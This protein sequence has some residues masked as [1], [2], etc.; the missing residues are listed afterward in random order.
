M[1]A[2][3]K[4][5]EVATSPVDEDTP[6]CILGRLAE[7]EGKVREQSEIIARIS[8]QINTANYDGQLEA[9]RVHS[10]LDRFRLEYALGE[11]DGLQDDYEDFQ[12]A[13]HSDEY[14]SAFEDDEPLVTI[15]IT[16]MNRADLLI[17][18]SLDSIRAQTYRR[19][20]VVVVG[21]H[22]TDDTAQRIASLG[23]PRIEFEN[24]P[25]RG[26]YPKPGPDRYL[27]A[28]TSPAIASLAKANGKFITHLDEDDRYEPHRIELL[29]S[30]ARQDRAD[31]LWHPFWWENADGSWHPLGSPTLQLGGTGTSMIFYHHYFKRIGWNPDAYRIQEPGDW[32]RIRRIRHL[33]PRLLYVDEMLTWHHALPARSPFEAQPG[34]MFR[35]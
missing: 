24:L 2:D 5:N 1:A 34:E 33:R 10:R 25:S 13:R 19:L 14:Q 26:P 28:G 30:K 9:L 35:D 27:V 32:N 31:F 7:L 16:T 22:C 21:D 6:E 29:V 12:K 15:C 11:L 17:E 4:G 23:D 20:Q 18:R 3:V 8:K